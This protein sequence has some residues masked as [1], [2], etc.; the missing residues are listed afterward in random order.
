LLVLHGSVDILGMLA[1]N[2][3]TAGAVSEFT[4]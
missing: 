1:T 4:E 2:Y 3:G